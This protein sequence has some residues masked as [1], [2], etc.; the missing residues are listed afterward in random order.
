MMEVGICSASTHLSKYELVGALKERKE[1]LRASVVL[2]TVCHIVGAHSCLLGE[3]R[4][5][6]WSSSGKR[7]TELGELQKGCLEGK[8]RG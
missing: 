2:L 5:F 3:R 7:E 4:T 6:L 1:A 8:E